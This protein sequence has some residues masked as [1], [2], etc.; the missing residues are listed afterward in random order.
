M[1]LNK[2]ARGDT[3]ADRGKNVCS[4]AERFSEYKLPLYKY[5][6]KC[7]SSV[8]EAEDLVQEVFL[9]LLKSN[10]CDRIDNL[11]SYIFRVAANTY[12]DYLRYYAVRSKGEH[13][14]LEDAPEPWS[15]IS[16]ERAAMGEQAVNKLKVELY[17]LPERTRDIFVMRAIQN[18]PYAEIA[19][20]MS[21]STRS[22]EKHTA[23]AIGLL[24]DVLAV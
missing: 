4:A 2:Y 21:I 5:F 18:R 9:R 3:C 10:S 15:E 17:K 7:V 22:A 13:C 24:G 8:D 11:D 16:A 23:K 19:E 6:L 14:S 1:K 20:L 12:K